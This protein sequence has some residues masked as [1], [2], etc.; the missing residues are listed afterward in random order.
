MAAKVN[1]AQAQ[2][3]LSVLE[4]DRNLSAHL[5]LLLQEERESL[6]LRQFKTYS[7]ILVRKQ[8]ALV[9]LESTD[10]RRRALMVE[11][12][13]S[14][15]SEGFTSFLKF[16]PSQWQKKLSIL[17]EQLTESLKQ[18]DKLNKINGKILLHS[19]IAIDRLMGL[20]KGQP[21]QQSTY[22]RSG[23]KG[24]VESNRCLAVA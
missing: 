9:E 18:C 10:S 13:F 16:I 17:W 5:L 22:T 21:T 4:K 20:I 6:E 24:Y 14:A 11:M 1:P 12:G 2:E 19:Q 3:L 23:R 15:D 8:Q 7:D